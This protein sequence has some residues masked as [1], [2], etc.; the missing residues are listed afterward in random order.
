LD[1]LIQGQAPQLI[2]CSKRLEEWIEKLPEI[3]M[4]EEEQVMWMD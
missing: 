3:K 1:Q 4:T 2:D